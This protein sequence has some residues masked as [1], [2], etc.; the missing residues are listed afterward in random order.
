MHGLPYDVTWLI[1]VSYLSIRFVIPGCSTVH[2]KS[3]SLNVP[4]FHEILRW[5]RKSVYQVELWGSRWHSW[6][7]HCTTSRKVSGSIPD[8]VIG[9]FHWHNPSDR[10]MTLG[11]TLPLTEMSTRNIFWGDKGGRCIGLTNLPPSCADYLEIWEPQPPGTLW[12]C[13]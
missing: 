5:L 9:I 6:L 7:R 13:N 2:M 1:N 12:A 11:L 10:T 8:C 3:F 4:Y